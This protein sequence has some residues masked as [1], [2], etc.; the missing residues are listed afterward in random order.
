MTGIVFRNA[1]DDVAGEG[2]G[3]CVFTEGGKLVGGFII[4][5]EAA[6]TGGYPYISFM[7]LYDIGDEVVADAAFVLW[8]VAIDDNAVAV[9]FVEPVAGAKPDKTAAVLE[10]VEDIVLGEA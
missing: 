8:V 3:A 7:I 1:A 5:I 2:G 4:A 9:V 10:N 6:A